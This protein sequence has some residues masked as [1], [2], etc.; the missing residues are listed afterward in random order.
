MSRPTNLDTVAS[1]HI[2]LCALG[3]KLCHWHAS[4]WDPIYAV[5]SY[6]NTGK[7]HPDR[8]ILEACR[9][10]IDRLLTK[11]LADWDHDAE[12][13]NECIDDLDVILSLWPAVVEA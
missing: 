8:D 11:A 10:E 7:V 13:L 4:Q 5:G 6:A 12:E 9:D 1:N 3:E 2:N